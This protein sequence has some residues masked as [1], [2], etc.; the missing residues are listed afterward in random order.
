[1]AVIYLP[2]DP[3]MPNL[4]GIGQ[5]L[6]E[7]ALRNAQQRKTT[8]ALQGAV[9]QLPHSGSALG[10]VQA[11]DQTNP[12]VQALAAAKGGADPRFALQI[13]QVGQEFK[14][15]QA[16]LEAANASTD[17]TRSRIAQMPME[18]AL[19][20]ARTN[21]TNAEIPLKQ[22]QLDLEDLR[23]RAEQERSSVLLPLE[24]QLKQ[25]QISEIQE[26]NPL[27][28]A[29]LASTIAANQQTI[30]AKKNQLDMAKKIIESLNLGGDKGKGISF[31]PTGVT[32]DALPATGDSGDFAG[33]IIT[34]Q[35]AGAPGE[36]AAAGGSLGGISAPD[37]L[38]IALDLMGMGGA[39]TKIMQATA[40]QVKI[41]KEKGGPA[42]TTE[43]TVQYT[44]DRT[45]KTNRQVLRSAD[46]RTTAANVE[47]LQRGERGSLSVTAATD[48]LTN[49]IQQGEKNGGQLGG[50]VAGRLQQVAL[51]LGI[52][53]GNDNATA[54]DSMTKQLF[55]MANEANKG[56]LSQR[57]FENFKVMFPKLSDADSVKKSKIAAINAMQD[58]IIKYNF[59]RFKDSQ[60]I[61]TKG[62]QELVEKRGLDKKSLG[63]LQKDFQRDLEKIHEGTS[64]SVDI[65]GTK[66]SQDDIAATAKARGLTEQQVIDTL[67]ESVK[68]KKKND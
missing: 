25:L 3:R 13:G 1:M 35:N 36:D 57:D 64:G 16:R 31:Q 47:D 32:S 48:A 51:N 10:G 58:V 54:F 29:E 46:M 2:R 21:A 42:G 4:S 34:A 28:R 9:D 68:G 67:R 7:V 41:E 5:A 61:P 43:Q 49:L 11:T 39:G 18:Q 50:P 6:T 55:A 59:E 19:L 22:R 60:Y 12:L 66:V 30:E 53:P 15:N 45:G 62:F 56:N 17:L 26:T 20:E 33:K 63:D 52:N 27:K 40:P 8:A 38:G 14:L 44:T 65:G 37:K 23:L 24:K